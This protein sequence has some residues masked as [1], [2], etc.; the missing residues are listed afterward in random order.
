M[1]EH[2]RPPY[3]MVVMLLGSGQKEHLE[4]RRKVRDELVEKGFRR[5]IIMEESPDDEYRDVSLDDKLR[6]IIDDFDPDLFVAFFHGNTRMDGVAFELGWLCCKFSSTEMDEK[7][8]IFLDQSFDWNETTSYIPSLEAH[9]QAIR[10]DESKQHS[11]A[12]IKLEKTIL[13]I[14]RSRLSRIINQ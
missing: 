9:V 8:R 11:K 1:T 3:D 2:T 6:R 4:F 10:F 5:I 14:Y 7:V 13:G 12:S